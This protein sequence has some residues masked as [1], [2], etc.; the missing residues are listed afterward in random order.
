MTDPTPPPTPTG[1][2]ADLRR[3]TLAGELVLGAFLDLASPIAAETCGRAGFDW[4][5]VDLEHGAAT[6]ADLLPLLLAIEGTPATAL[7]RPQS[8]ERLRIGRALDLGAG[9]IMVPRLDTAEQAREAVTFLRYPPAGA[10]GVALR[11]RGLHLGSIPHADVSHMNE[12]ILGIVQIE[13][14]AAVGE[15]DAIAAIDGVDVLFV[16]PADLSHSLGVP[17]Q[18]GDATFKAALRTVVEACRAHGKSPGIL[19]YDP[20]TFGPY[21]ELGFRFVGV[22][23]ESAFIADRAKAMLGA[24]PHPA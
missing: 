2:G 14:A 23:S 20:A 6:E 12:S 15:A 18:F 3:R 17:G 22:G 16:G 21:V 11:T 24:V 5:I 19:L 1:R 10:R 13:S 9:G 8:G 4:L 7:V